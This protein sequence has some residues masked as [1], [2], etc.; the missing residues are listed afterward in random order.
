MVEPQLTFLG[1]S[2]GNHRIRNKTTNKTFL[3]SFFYKNQIQYC[4]QH[5]RGNEVCEE[6]FENGVKKKEAGRCWPNNEAKE[7]NL[8]N[9]LDYNFEN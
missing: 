9:C 7:E 2:I 3:K 1:N 8:K 5:Y 6:L 4:L